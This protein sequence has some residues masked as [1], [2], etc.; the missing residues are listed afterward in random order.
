MLPAFLPGS[1]IPGATGLALILV[2]PVAAG[3]IIGVLARRADA[4]AGIGFVAGLTGVAVGSTILP[5]YLYVSINL[6]FIMG[7]AAGFTAA[8]DNLVVKEMRA[9]R[10]KQVW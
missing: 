7:V 3:S 2:G 4:A 5:Q 10:K 9:N 1:G 6:G 8:L